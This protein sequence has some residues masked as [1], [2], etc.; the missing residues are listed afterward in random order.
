MVLD[1][2]ALVFQADV[3]P[4]PGAKMSTQAPTLE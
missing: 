1:A 2:V 4:L 3:M